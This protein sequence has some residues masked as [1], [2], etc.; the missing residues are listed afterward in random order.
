M[1]SL[2]E[3]A[4][5]EFSELGWD[6]TDDQMQKMACEN[7]LELLDVLENQGHTNFSVQYVLSQFN[8]LARFQP[9][10]Q[11]K[12]EPRFWAKGEH[13]GQH[14]KEFSLFKENGVIKWQNGIVFV[15]PRNTSWQSSD[16]SVIV[17]LPCYRQD[18]VTHRILVDDEDRCLNDE[19]FN[20]YLALVPKMVRPDIERRRPLK[21]VG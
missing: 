8:Q 2:I 7:I 5:R 17:E 1:A 12:D 20:K 11:I 16:S 6:K 13:G 10:T 14:S 19:E 4:K 21:S 18:L 3:Y 15:T 9:I